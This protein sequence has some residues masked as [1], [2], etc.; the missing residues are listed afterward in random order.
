MDAS[1]RIEPL[2]PRALALPPSPIRALL[3][4]RVEDPVL[5]FAGG[6][7]DPAL[8]PTSALTEA[9]CRV[10]NAKSASA[11]QYAP[12][13]GL[14][15]LREFIAQRLRGRGYYI[16]PS[17]VFVTHGSQHALC[18]VTQVLGS[19]NKRAMLEQP[20]YP[21][22]LQ[23]FTL[24]ECPVFPLPVTQEGWELDAI[25]R[26][27]PDI[28]YVIPHFHNPTG[29]CATPEQKRKLALSA[30]KRGIYVI[31][32]DAYGE[33]D[34]DGCVQKPLVSECPD[35]GVLVGSFS[36]TL[37]PG[38]R[39]GYVVAPKAIQS[40]LVATLQTTALQPGTLTQY[41]ASELLSLIDYESHLRRLREHY[42]S[43]AEALSRVCQ[44]YEFWHR[45]ATG[46]FFLWVETKL[47]AKDVAKAMAERG[48]KTVPENAFCFD[49]LCKQG[50]HLRLSFPRLSLDEESLGRVEQSFAAASG[51]LVG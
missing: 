48:M 25:G 18:A 14:S 8:F 31:E 5:D 1:N 44:K 32:D 43:R 40:A 29:R 33:L 46:G 22:A 28:L 41:L 37:C 24:A 47:D 27:N 39:L 38:L 50:S 49:N 26:T 7:P 42:R 10:F 13:E 35:F 2:A 45:Q 34:F 51:S 15:E 3:N 17:D 6:I 20:V 4:V 11:L 9:S 30:Q 21:G 19:R 23:A 16:E 36:K 12:T